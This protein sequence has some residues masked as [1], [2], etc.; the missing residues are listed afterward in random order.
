MNAAASSNVAIL[1][2]KCYEAEAG[3]ATSMASS[4]SGKGKEKETLIG[5]WERMVKECLSGKGW[6]AK[7]EAMKM[8]LAMR[9]EEKSK[10]ALKPWLPSLV[11]L[12]EDGDGNVRDQAREVS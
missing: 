10:L 4:G 1:G 6:R 11:E 7:V 8:L 2:R 9:Q 12:L 3:T 5:Y